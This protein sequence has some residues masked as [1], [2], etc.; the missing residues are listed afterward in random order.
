MLFYLRSLKL[1]IVFL[2]NSGMLVKKS[3]NL[4]VGVSWRLG[5]S[6]LLEKAP[7]LVFFVVKIL[8][9]DLA[10]IQNVHFLWKML[11][12]T[13]PPRKFSSFS[14]NINCSV[15]NMQILSDSLTKV[16]NKKFVHE[17]RH[18]CHLYV[19]K[20]VFIYMYNYIKQN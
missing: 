2:Q 20:Y 1:I 13:H 10:K 15:P 8:I 4:L 17:P 14:K 3:L 9:S 18:A 11:F 5:L 19:Y 7:N 12:L 6:W 16:G